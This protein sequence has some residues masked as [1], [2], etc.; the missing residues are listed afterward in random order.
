MKVELPI[1]ANLPHEYVPGERL[2]LEAYRKIAEVASAEALQGVREELVDRYGPLPVPVENLMRV[3][4]LRV[5]ARKAG[6]TDITLQGNH[7]RFAPVE[8]PDSG[9]VRLKRFYPGTLLKPQMHSVLVPRPTTA[10]V[11]GQTLRDAAMLDWAE[12]FI[13]T[14]LLGSVAAAAAAAVGH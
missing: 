7:V 8:L 2:R 1:D 12:A 14:V 11:G 10:R 9:E 3:A 5:K 6:L 13:D 4:K